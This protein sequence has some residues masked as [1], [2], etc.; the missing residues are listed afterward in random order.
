MCCDSQM[1]VYYASETELLCNEKA[2][3]LKDTMY[4][5][6]RVF[7]LIFGVIS[8]LVVKPIHPIDKATDLAE[9][10]SLNFLHYL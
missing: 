8:P 9:V 1:K 5:F 4:C 10:L 2:M 6:F 3:V 7:I